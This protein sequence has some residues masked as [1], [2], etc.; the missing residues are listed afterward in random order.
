[1]I[2]PVHYLA[3]H[4]LAECMRIDHKTSVGVRC[5]FDSDKDIEIVAVIVLIGAFA[6]NLNILLRCPVSFV[7]LVGAIEIFSSCQIDHC[8]IILRPKFV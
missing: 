4:D 8:D 5:T 7:K 3:L 1:M 6:K 2:Q